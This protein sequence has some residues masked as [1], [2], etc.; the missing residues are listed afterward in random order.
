M[1]FK[2]NC[3]MR[4]SLAEVIVPAVL[5]EIVALGLEKLTRLARLKDSARN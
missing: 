2:A 5:A 4:G 1:Y 3:K